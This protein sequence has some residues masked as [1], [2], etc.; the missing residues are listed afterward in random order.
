MANP[1]RGEL[2]ARLEV[3]AKKKRSVKWKSQASLEGVPPARSKILKAGAF[4]SPSP[5][6]AMPDEVRR[7]RFSAV[8][9]EDSLL[10]HAKLVAGA[11][12]SILRDSDLKK[13]HALSIEEALTLL[14]QGATSV[15]PSASADPFLYYF[16]FVN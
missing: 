6:L 2:R 14:L 15:R 5:L 4:S 7:D 3:L 9:G 8:G 12:S 11:I 1:T 10:S 16:S 13:V